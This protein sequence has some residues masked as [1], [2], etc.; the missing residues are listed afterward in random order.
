MKTAIARTSVKLLKP[1]RYDGHKR[2]A[3]D[4][5]DVKARDAVILK[6][7]G[8]AEDAPKPT[9][10]IVKPT[11]PMAPATLPDV[12][13]FPP[14]ADLPPLLPHEPKPEPKKTRRREGE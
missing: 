6:A 7:L 11:P 5:V 14:I 4:V 8:F 9:P 10:P 13:T 3:G 2:S 12:P 1:Y